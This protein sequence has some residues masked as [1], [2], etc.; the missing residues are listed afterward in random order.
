MRKQD[1]IEKTDLAPPSG[2][3]VVDGEHEPAHAEDTQG[4]PSRVLI[5]DDDEGCRLLLRDLFLDAGFA[6]T[7]AAGAESALSEVGRAVPDLVVTDLQ[8]PRVGGLELCRQ[9]Q[10]IDRELPVIMM[11]AR[12]DVQ[13]VVESL[14]AGAVDYLTKP[15]QL[16]IVLWRVQRTLARCAEKAAN[17]TLY[18]E[19][20]ES[21]VLSS[22]RDRA[23]AEVQALQRAQLNALLEN[24]NEGVIIGDA[25]GEVVLRNRAAH[26]LFGLPR[27]EPP[28]FTANSLDAFLPDGRALGTEERPL[29]RATRG[30]EFTDYELVFV[31][32]TGER[33]RLVFTATNVK[34][35]SGEV[36][37]A[38]LVFRDITEMRRLE[39]QR[40]DYLALTTHDLR[41]PLT[42][43]LMSV[44]E[45]KASMANTASRTGMRAAERAER[46]VRRMVAMLEDLS[47]AT[48]LETHGVELRR[49]S[50]D[51]AELVTDMID[52]MDAAAARRIEIQIDRTGSFRLLADR[53]RLERV[54]LNL[55]TNALKYSADE[56][57]VQV[58]VA[59]DGS[60]L[61]LDVVDHGIGIDRENIEMIFS[62]YY[63]T[64]AGKAAA[65]GSGLGLY[66]VRMIV[67]AHGGRID[68]SSDVGKGSR[69]SVRLPAL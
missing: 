58:R 14:R 69:F 33:R 28:A 53:L 63:R 48:Q 15:L 52:G 11:T 16:D 34:E 1:A 19:L 65:P 62:R 18:R 45:L 27:A 56:S 29:A 30:E 35:E 57:P 46:N 23:H 21:L 42:T 68:V 50:C 13:S 39:Q 24:L 20:N 3:R 61:E 32:A 9:L 17:R 5:V 7:T 41:G 22:L 26:A 59:R 40:R 25:R 6:V 60:A 12:S 64:D 66:I 43:I 67:E 31:L 44:T 54:V 36:A 47:E 37:L 2:T 8:M 4:K 38:I 49:V 10:Q 55:L 51:L